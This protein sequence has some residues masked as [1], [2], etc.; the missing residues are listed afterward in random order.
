MSSLR[1]KSTKKSS[2]SELMSRLANA[3]HILEESSPETRGLLG[4][5]QTPISVQ[6]PIPAPARYSHTPLPP[7]PSLVATKEEVKDVHKLID[8]LTKQSKIM[9]L[10]RVDD[11]AR[12][13][14]ETSV[15]FSLP[16]KQTR[17][18]QREYERI[19]QQ[20]D[21]ELP[22]Y[23]IEGIE[24][25]P[26]IS[27]DLWD[28][29]ADHIF[30]ES[31]DKKKGCVNSPRLGV[32]IGDRR[33]T[34]VCDRCKRYKHKTYGATGCAGHLGAIMLGRD[35]LGGNT[36]GLSHDRIYHPEHVR[37]IAMYLICV[38]P[39]C[40]GLLISEDFI[41]S[42]K[43][44]KISNPYNRLKAIEKKSEG[45]ICNRTGCT[46][47]SKR[48]YHVGNIKATGEIQYSDGTNGGEKITMSPDDVFIILN[49]ITD[50][51]VA[52]LGGLKVTLPEPRY[53]H[54]RDLL[55]WC[56]PVTPPQARPP[57]VVNGTLKES[58]FTEGYLRIVAAS[59][60]WKTALDRDP[61]RATIFRSE[62]TSEI[63]RFMGGKAEAGAASA[64]I[65][66]VRTETTGKE[67]IIRSHLMSSRVNF[68]G[69]SIV[70]VDPFLKFGELGIPYF[71]ARILTVKET[72]SVY[73][74]ES[75]I[76]KLRA[77]KVVWYITKIVD[78]QRRIP[79]D[80]ENSHTIELKIGDIIEREL[81]NGDRVVSGRQ[82]TLH[83]GSL[84]SWRAYVYPKGE[85]VSVRGPNGK[86]VRTASEE[87][88][89]LGYGLW[90]TVIMNMDFD[91]DSATLYALQ[92]LQALAE[93]KEIVSV[94]SCFM[95]SQNNSPAMG[96][97]YDAPTSFYLMTQPDTI[98]REDLFNN[99]LTGMLDRRPNLYNQIRKRFALFPFWEKVISETVMYIDTDGNV[100]TDGNVD[101]VDGINVS[102]KVTTTV[103]KI[104]HHGQVFSSTLV[105]YSDGRNK[106]E[107]LELLG[108]TGRALFST[109]F[110]DD[111]NYIHASD[112]DNIIEIK[113]GLLI[114][115]QINSQQL[116][117]VRNSIHHKIWDNYP[118]DVVS[119]YM[120]DA[121]SMATE[122]ITARGL[123]I[124]PGDCY[125]QTNV[126]IQRQ[127]ARQDT[128]D[129]VVKHMPEDMRSEWLSAGKVE[130]QQLFGKV[131]D[132]MSDDMKA[133]FLAAQTPVKTQIEERIHKEV[134]KAE[135][136][137]Q[138]LGPEKPNKYVEILRKAE[139]QVIRT[140]MTSA[141]E[142]IVDTMTSV[143]NSFYIQR[144]SGAKGKLSNQTQAYGAVGQHY[145]QGEPPAKTMTCGTRC[146]P[147][148]DPADTS[149]SSIG[150]GSE[151]LFAGLNPITYFMHQASIR[152]Q[153]VTSSTEASTTG[154]LQRIIT[155]SVEDLTLRNDGTVRNSQNVVFQ[156]IYGYDGMNPDNI[157]RSK[158]GWSFIS[159]PDRIKR[160]ESKL[161]HV[162]SRFI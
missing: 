90:Y 91:G 140:N 115:G 118:L 139:A 137:L 11:E 7:V 26:F 134:Q 88:K 28:L 22:E 160:Y 150:Y 96:L 74:L 87:A 127:Q 107:T 151:S 50:E 31:A 103:K 51:S 65:E 133:K 53:V 32:T 106:E 46:Y 15:A 158:D 152:P 8:P 157:L 73:N 58:P 21:A 33:K 43:L 102:V 161:R 101:T 30:I 70:T 108:Y 110:R 12:I 122:W 86:L 162:T 13:E 132:G 17:S 71:M 49:G 77:G 97:Y 126:D 39:G 153:L 143:E 146:L 60:K 16:V 75:C 80:Y 38:C 95:N 40:S 61:A 24:Y 119:D 9:A 92:T 64:H 82:P 5:Q 141:I 45:H 44:D 3:P 120:T 10:S 159:V 147:H 83:K 66:T 48:V 113:N 47:R 154:A 144:K 67:S 104:Y 111:F 114:S 25:T 72:V 34:E 81:Q 99:I 27:Q 14:R 124:S 76:Q 19:M 123:T 37:T 98:V 55:M 149:L 41:K 29:K 93:L 156:S 112:P 100:N 148:F 63:K 54:P 138:S 94:E 20:N 2:A 69:R 109:L 42:E 129:E 155:K 121:G 130:R 56:F 135:L 52:L 57:M 35:M 85:M 62:L 136:Y 78:Q 68:T 1:G 4:S 142:K 105:E 79:V 6:R 117:N 36:V 59:N 23:E 131:T 89:F 18:Q 125:V 84:M 145:V 116:G 128:L